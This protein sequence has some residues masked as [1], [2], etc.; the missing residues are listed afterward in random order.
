MKTDFFCHG[1]NLCCVHMDKIME[2]KHKA[3][4][5]IRDMIDAFPYSHTDGVCDMLT[6]DGCKVYKD[7]PDMCSVEKVYDKAYS[8]LAEE[9]YLDMQYRVCSILMEKDG[10]TREE[11]QKIYEEGLKDKQ[12]LKSVL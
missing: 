7:R 12:F 4:D 11:I 8:H 1:C 5:Q 9:D 10:M 6:P 2:N 3:T